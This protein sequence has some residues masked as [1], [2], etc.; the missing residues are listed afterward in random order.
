[1]QPSIPHTDEVLLAT[2][3]IQDDPDDLELA[4]A[5]DDGGDDD[6][7]GEDD[8]DDEQ[9]A[10]EDEGNEEQRERREHRQQRLTS[11]APQLGQQYL[12]R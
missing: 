3:E 2:P 8:G 4:A 5:G 1:M 7:A 6:A 10:G 12:L 11:S 9:A